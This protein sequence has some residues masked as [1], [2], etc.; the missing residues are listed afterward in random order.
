MQLYVPSPV[1]LVPC[2]V[3]WS[4]VLPPPLQSCTRL[5]PRALLGGNPPTPYP[6]VWTVQ[7]TPIVHYLICQTSLAH[8][9]FGSSPSVTVTK[10][11]CHYWTQQYELLC[12]SCCY[13]SREKG[14]PPSGGIPPSAKQGGEGLC[15]IILDYGQGA[16]I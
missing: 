11:T 16:G 10:Q 6:A 12:G 3:V 4:L 14:S 15:P 9:A 13:I 8:S 7:A 2:A 5:S 1:P